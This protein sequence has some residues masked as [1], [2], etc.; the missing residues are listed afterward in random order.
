[1]TFGERQ[2]F[3]EQLPILALRRRRSQRVGHGVSLSAAFSQQSEHAAEEIVGVVGCGSAPS[4]RDPV[5]VLAS[6]GEENAVGVRAAN[7]GANCAGDRLR[8]ISAMKRGYFVG[9]VV[10]VPEF[11]RSSRN[12]SRSRLRMCRVRPIFADGSAPLVRKP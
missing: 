1:V 2:A 3:G 11:I 7:V 10:E 9:V 8:F 12:P 4:I 6:P 5:E